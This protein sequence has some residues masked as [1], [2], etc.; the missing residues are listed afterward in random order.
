MKAI[1]RSIT[2]LAAAGLAALLFKAPAEAQTYT[3]AD[4]ALGQEFQ[5]CSGT[6]PDYYPSNSL[7][8]LCWQVGSNCDN[9]ALITVV[10]SN[11]DPFPPLGIYPG[12]PG[13]IG[14]DVILGAPANTILDA[15]ATVNSVTL[16]T[17]GGLRVWQTLTANSFNFLGDGSITG[18][19]AAVG[20]GDLVIASG[21]SLTKWGGDG[22]LDFG[23]GRPLGVNVYGYN[24]TLAILSG[25]LQVPF[26]T[27]NGGL[28]YNAS[29]VFSNNASIVAQAPD[30]TNYAHGFIGTLTGSGTG[31][32]FWNQGIIW[33]QG[34]D[35]VGN[36]HEALT[37]NF[38]GDMFQWSGGYFSAGAAT[39]L[40]VINITT[41]DVGLN[42]SPLFNDGVINFAPGSVF[43]LIG[44]SAVFSNQADGFAYLSGDFSITGDGQV[45]NYGL[46]QKTGGTNTSFIYPK[47][48]QYGGTLEVD[49]G[50]LALNFSGGNYFT[51]ATLVVSN[52]AMLELSTPNQSLTFEGAMTGLGGGTV[53][54]NSGT[55]GSEYGATLNFPGPM[56]Q[57]QGGTLNG[58]ANIVNVGTINVSGPVNVSGWLTN[59]GTI[60]QSGDGSIASVS[61]DLQNNAGGTYNLQNDNSV[62][63]FGFN[64]YG[65]LEKTA[66]TGTNSL[67]VGTFNNYGSITAATGG[68]DFSSSG[69]NQNAGTLQLTPALTFSSVGTLTLNGGTITGVGALGGN[70]GNDYVE[71]EG[72]VLAPG[73][74]YGT[75]NVPNHFQMSAGAMDI[76]LGGPTQFSQLTAGTDIYLF[77]GTLNVTLAGGYAPAIGTQFPILSGAL[78]N[79]SAFATLNVPPG[80][81]VTYSNTG[82]YLTMTGAV[83]VQ[84]TGPR[85]SGTNFVFGFNTVPNQSYSVFA[86]TDLATTNWTF[87]TNLT[88]DGTLQQIVV[89]ALN[90][91]RR[92][93]R[94]REP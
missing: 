87:F 85:L 67:N 21:G 3:W 33:C 66:G 24:C 30:S 91:P 76:Q 40:G 56:F 63:L 68:L 41:A 94:V 81:S 28:F 86:N 84:I 48:M 53:L 17:D 1:T 64:N 82:V 45:W 29:L 37:L 69:F 55:W 7:W 26:G 72:G 49:S 22:T 59:N 75:I 4:N 70:G 77:G 34:W 73:N 18:A 52:G 58:S 20:G 74:P 54:V 44:G 71:V 65:L 15:N 12:G 5:H 8:S 90:P 2:M 46:I 36:W 79:G 62:A 6:T 51:N 89:P 88:G 32:L 39:N 93:F 57:W 47:Y 23:I 60:V 50:T 35:S 80:L 43:C 11:W 61:Y 16:Q 10:P 31:H 38:P 42:E 19:G 27:G 78:F 14:V 9:T 13:A 25:T 92:F 83:P